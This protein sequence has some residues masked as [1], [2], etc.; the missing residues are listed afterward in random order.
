MTGEDK[1]NNKMNKEELNALRNS[2]DPRTLRLIEV[3][4]QDIIA[5]ATAETTQRL[6][7]LQRQLNALQNRQEQIPQLQQDLDA[8]RRELPRSRARLAQVLRAERAKQ[9]GPNS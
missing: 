8:I 2:S 7:A 6:N 1:M 4:T 5:N 3:I 9:K